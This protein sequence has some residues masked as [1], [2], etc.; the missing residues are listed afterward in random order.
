MV[1]RD[2]PGV[3]ALQELVVPG[4]AAEAPWQDVLQERIQVGPEE[5]GAVARQLLQAADLGEMEVITEP[6]EQAVALAALDPADV[7]YVGV[8]QHL[9]PGPEQPG[10]QDAVGPGPRVLEGRVHVGEHVDRVGRRRPRALHADGRGFRGTVV[11]H[12]P[13]AGGLDRAPARVGVRLT[14]QQ[15]RHPVERAA[16]LGSQGAEPGG[17]GGRA[18]HARRGTALG[19]IGQRLHHGVE[20]LERHDGRRWRP[21]R[22][23]GHRVNPPRDEPICRRPAPRGDEPARVR[24]A[25]SAHLSWRLARPG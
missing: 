20:P 8:E 4:G 25:D 10:Q 1:A 17:R 14:A 13:C 24:L 23:A 12:A 5:R 2:A 19:Q 16:P 18:E 21:R 22:A 15:E 11:R 7:A 6:T 9:R 3:L